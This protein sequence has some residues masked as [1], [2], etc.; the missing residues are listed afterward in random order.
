MS[1]EKKTNFVDISSNKQVKKLYNKKGRARR[2][3]CI[4][5]SVIFMLTGGGMVYYYSVLNSMNY[6]DLSDQDATTATS[7]TAAEPIDDSNLMPLSDDDLIQHSKV[8]N[9]MLFGTDSRGGSENPGSDTMMMASIDNAHKKLKLTSFQRDT[10]VY[11]PGYGNDKLTNV[12]SYGGAKLAIQ[13]LEANFGVKIDRYATVDFESF[14]KIIDTLGGVEIEVTDDEILYINYQMYKN[15][16]ADD[17]NTITDSAGV[18]KLTGQEALWYARNR[19]LSTSE[20]GNEI[21]L[22]GDDWDRTSRQ[23]KL[24]ETMFSSMKS[25]DLGQIVSIVSQV[26]PLVTTNLKKDEITALV[27]NALKYLQYDVEQYTVPSEGYWYYDNDTPAG[28]AIVIADLEAQRKAF[29]EFI[30]EDLISGST[31]TTSSTTA[32]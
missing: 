26:G 4:V 24:L 3:V 19:G 27:S 16:Q 7:A 17:M 32:N 29:A 21:G 1:N 10:Y 18:V 13:T 30:Y 9:I 6:V 15:G 8:L 25:A 23:R 20:D 5:L 28:S 22:D 12:Y 31:S 2:I 11:I 14:I